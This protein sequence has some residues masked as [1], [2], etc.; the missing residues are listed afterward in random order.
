MRPFRFNNRVAIGGAALA[1]LLLSMSVL[2]ADESKAPVPAGVQ[3]QDGVPYVPPAD[4]YVPES[5]KAIPADA[6]KRG[7]T[8]ILIRN[9]SGKQPKEIMNLRQP[10]PPAASAPSDRSDSKR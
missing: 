6:G 10:Q 5:S 2:I 8:N 7:H 3:S 9:P 1:I 4:V